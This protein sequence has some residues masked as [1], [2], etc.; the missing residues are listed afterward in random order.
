MKKFYTLFLGIVMLSLQSKSQCPQTLQASSNGFCA[1]ATWATPPSPLPAS[2]TITSTVYSLVSGNGTV[3]VPAVYQSGGGN[4]ACNAS[5]SGFTGAITISTGSVCFYSN[6]LLGSEI[7]LPI[8]L[9]N[10][11][12]K[13][14]TNGTIEFH[15]ETGSEENMQAFEIQTS[16]DGITYITA[17]TVAAN[18]RASKYTYTLNTFAGGNIFLR[19]KMVENTGK[20]INSNILQY[21]SNKDDRSV[22]RPTISNSTVVLYSK[23]NTQAQTVATLYNT[24]GQSLKKINILSGA[25]MIDISDLNQGMYILKLAS[26]EALRFVKQ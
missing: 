25:T 6:G 11:G 7:T 2:I 24:Q 26:G 14:V 20:A 4:G 9:V 21:N 22:L 18:N 17:A 13:E 10:F 15:W 1:I 3:A 5:Q 12:Y 23:N 16:T 19:L 8:K